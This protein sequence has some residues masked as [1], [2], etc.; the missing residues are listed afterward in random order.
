[1]LTE[2]RTELEVAFVDVLW[3]EKL[4]TIPT[5]IAGGGP[6]IGMSLLENQRITIDVKENGKVQIEPLDAI[7]IGSDQE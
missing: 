6:L 2:Q 7:D 4:K 3:N 5:L 1:M